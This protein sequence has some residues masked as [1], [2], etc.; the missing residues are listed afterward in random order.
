MAYIGLKNAVIA[1]I[2]N[3]T[4][5]QAIEYDTGMVFG[6]TISANITLNNA[7]SPL[8]ADDVVVEDDNATTGG[9][10]ELNLAD[11]SDEVKAYALGYKKGTDS[12]EGNSQRYIKTGEG[13]PYVGFGF[14][15]TRVMDGKRSYKA[16]WI[17]KTQFALGAIS[18]QTKGQTVSWQTPTVSGTIMGVQ[19]DASLTDNFYEES[20]FN[21][22][23]EADAYLKKMAAI[24]APAT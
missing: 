17:Y 21:T 1:R 9:T 14:I 22:V 13:A 6:K 10:A 2:K 20:S 18:A 5:G 7:S 16:Y 19:N 15:R 24:T 8:Y 23:A 12:G 4:Q 3:E 11:I